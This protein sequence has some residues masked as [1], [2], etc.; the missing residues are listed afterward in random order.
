M[1]VAY[2]LLAVA[3]IGTLSSWTFLALTIAG[4][5]KFHRD[6]KTQQAQ[7][8]SVPQASLP[9]VSL[10][11]PVHGM[12]SGLRENI[13]SF[14]HLDY[15]SYEILFA[16]DLEDNQALAVVREIC[17]RYP[18]I[19]TQIVV[20]GRSLCKLSGAVFS[21]SSDRTTRSAI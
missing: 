16:A 11:K 10:L 1:L 8:R 17:S 19:P 7:A 9:P 4:A 13:E 18:Q 5:M 12:E 21:I 15:P 2:I 14:F 3:V 20:T 6:A